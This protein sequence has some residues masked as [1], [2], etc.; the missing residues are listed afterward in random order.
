MVIGVERGR[1]GTRWLQS[2]WHHS[3]IKVTIFACSFCGSIK[4][5]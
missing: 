2:F 4:Y 5:P 3:M 1:C